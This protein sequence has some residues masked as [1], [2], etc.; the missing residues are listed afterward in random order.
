MTPPPPNLAQL[1][2]QR[3]GRLAGP[4]RIEP[5]EA[6]HITLRWEIA[7]Q[8]VPEHAR[9]APAAAKSVRL[10]GHAAPPAPA[11]PGPYLMLEWTVP[12]EIE[13]GRGAQARA[14]MVDPATG[15]RVVLATV[16]RAPD[17]LAGPVRI[18]RDEDLRHIEID[19]LLSAT[20]RIGP[21]LDGPAGPALI[22]VLYAR[23]SLLTQLG[24]AGGR[25]EPAH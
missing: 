17:D 4:A 10:N 21:G 7:A 11:R 15:D 1:A 22:R 23:T 14:E 20:L 16:A 2:T 12:L 24:I 3:A 18:T 25:Y 13:P 19:G 6:R 8:A 9:P 5:A